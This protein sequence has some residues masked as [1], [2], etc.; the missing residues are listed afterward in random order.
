MPLFRK[1]NHRKKNAK[2][3]HSFS[4]EQRERVKKI[5]AYL[6]HD[7]AVRQWRDTRERTKVAELV[8]K[9]METY[10]FPGDFEQYNRAMHILNLKKMRHGVRFAGVF[11]MDGKKRNYAETGETPTGYELNLNP[12][13]KDPKTLKNVAWKAFK[14]YYMRL[15]GDSKRGDS[16]AGYI[17][18]IVIYPVLWTWRTIIL[19]LSIGGRLVASRV[20]RRQILK[21]IRKLEA[22][23]KEA[24]KSGKTIPL[25]LFVAHIEDL[26]KGGGDKTKEYFKKLAF[27]EE[28]EKKKKKST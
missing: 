17:F 21:D 20:A 27:P 8:K 18:G 25:A 23:S 9:D 13:R 11:G 22:D 14:D 28:K 26:Q 2:P 6:T 7:S 1:K 5:E 19:P 16:K 12:F 10:Q 24:E 3:L 4:A 15:P